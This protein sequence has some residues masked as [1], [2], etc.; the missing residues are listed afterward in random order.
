[1][2]S[3]TLNLHIQPFRLLTKAEAAHY[4]GLSTKKFE[5]QCPVAPIE[6]AD[7]S[8]LWDVHDLDRWIETL[9]CDVGDDASAIVARLE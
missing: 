3:T 4:C 6:M 8:M 2:P 5:S 9:K 7:G 1:M